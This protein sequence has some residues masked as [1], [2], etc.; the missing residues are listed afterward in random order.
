MKK[1]TYIII[2][3]S[4]WY[5]IIGFSLTFIM[6]L[7]NSETIGAIFSLIFLIIFTTIWFKTHKKY[8][9]NFQKQIK[10]NTV[11]LNKNEFKNINTNSKILY[12]FTEEEFNRMKETL[13]KNW[14]I[15][16]NKKMIPSDNDVYWAL[17]NGKIIT[18]NNLK[19]I[20]KMREIQNTILSEEKNTR[21]ISNTLHQLNNK[22]LK[23]FISDLEKNFDNDYLN[24]ILDDKKTIKEHMIESYKKQAYLNS[25]QAKIDFPKEINKQYQYV[26][27]NMDNR[28]NKYPTM[29]PEEEQIIK[30]FLEKVSHI[31]KKYSIHL[32]RFGHGMIRIEYNGCP[33]GQFNL[34]NEKYIR[35]LR[36][37]KVIDKFDIPFNE[38]L[39]AVDSW[40][41][42][43]K[44]QLA[45]TR[46]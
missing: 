2:N 15:Q 40:V 33:T 17:T 46:F 24:T 28:S 35:F 25:K 39:L 10:K 34:R 36:G 6:L 5:F 31:R 7:I 26:I 44:Y 37:M 27:E 38:M 41:R 12:G 45:E 16:Y 4:L 14:S 1:I 21:A 8:S 19:V 32:I 13:I 20:S 9:K 3:I 22:D 43:C 29:T 18:S 23:N 42:Y 30:T 11:Y